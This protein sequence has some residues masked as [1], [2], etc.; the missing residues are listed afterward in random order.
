MKIT[1]VMV[2]VL[3]LGGLGLA[4]QAAAVCSGS[5][6]EIAGRS[7]TKSAGR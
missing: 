1:S 4:G 5:A 7:I 6:L 3:L 2:G